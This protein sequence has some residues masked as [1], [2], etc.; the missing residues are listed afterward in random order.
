VLT[1]LSL[2]INQAM[3][4]H[5]GLA[6]LAALLNML[7]AV[8]LGLALGV[9]FERRQQLQM[10]G[11][12]ILMIILIPVFLSIL[13]PVLPEWLRDVFDWTPG[14][15]LAKAFRFSFSQGAM[16]AQIAANLGLALGCT[17]PIFA[18]IVWKVRR[19]YL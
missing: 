5:W 6:V 13:E 10:W 19:S 7:F 8:S 14:M 15:A 3:V 17:V 12:T 11:M 16:P 4:T 2:M 18:V 9:F 1:S